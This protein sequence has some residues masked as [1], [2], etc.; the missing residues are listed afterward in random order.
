MPAARVIALQNL[1]IA[2]AIPFDTPAPI[3][4]N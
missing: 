4:H 1:L 2:A 3:E